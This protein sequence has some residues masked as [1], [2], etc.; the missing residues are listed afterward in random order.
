LEIHA[1]DE[2]MRSYLKANISR[3]PQCVKQ[4]RDLQGE[5]E[6]KVINI[7]NGIYAQSHDIRI[8]QAS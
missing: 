7:V 8:D 1:S 5:I 4:S 2:D 6:T 3:L